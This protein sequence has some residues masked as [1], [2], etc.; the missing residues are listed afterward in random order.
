[1]NFSVM[2]MIRDN[3]C[4]TYTTHVPPCPQ[5]LRYNKSKWYINLF[6][7]LFNLT[8]SLNKYFLLFP[9]FSSS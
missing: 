5:C 6:G 9:C 7:M 1:M 8:I 4:T 3:N 2:L